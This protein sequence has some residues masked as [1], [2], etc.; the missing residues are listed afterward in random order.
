MEYEHT[1]YHCHAPA[2]FLCDHVL[3]FATDKQFITL[4]DEMITCSRPIC[5][6]CRTQVGWTTLGGFDTMDRCR[7]HADVGRER[8]HPA[9]LRQ[10]LATKRR[11][12]IRVI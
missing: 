3:G 10:L 8:P 11:L 2:E 9:P 7:D 4:D 1:C 5:S 6:E 12:Q